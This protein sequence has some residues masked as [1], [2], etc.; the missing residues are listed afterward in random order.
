MKGAGR[1]GPRGYISV[2]L[3]VPPFVSLTVPLFY[4]V[5]GVAEP[6]P[7]FVSLLQPLLPLQIHP[8]GQ[9]KGIKSIR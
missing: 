6:R 4:L 1:L 7:L 5:A 8:G 2:T 9:I 3:P